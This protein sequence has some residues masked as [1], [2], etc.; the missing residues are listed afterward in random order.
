M[1][2]TKYLCSKCGQK[3]FPP[4]GKKCVFKD[5]EDNNVAGITV[6]L[7]SKNKKGSSLMQATKTPISKSD[8]L[9][10]DSDTSS[11]E[12]VDSSVDS[13]S[14]S[15]DTDHKEAKQPMA[16]TSTSQNIQVQILKELQRVSSRLEVV[17]NKVADTAAATQDPK[18]DIQK[19]SSFSKSKHVSKHCK[20]KKSCYS[21]SDSSSE[22]SDA[23]DLSYLRSNKR[24]Q[25]KVD[26]RLVELEK[27]CEAKGKSEKLKSKRGGPLMFWWKKG[28]RGLMMLF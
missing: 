4:T 26:D 19:L 17:E 13:P 10:S 28:W 3:R 11:D 9:L 12:E 14:E 6:K 1:G 8:T 16:G 18:K 21:S 25:K 15:S 7:R 23:P 22:D 20:H 27:N 5:S 24:I 2:K